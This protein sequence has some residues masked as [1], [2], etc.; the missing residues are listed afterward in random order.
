MT[1]PARPDGGGSRTASRL[2]Q[3]PPRRPGA[4]LAVR[5]VRA[6][7]VR[8]PQVPSAR[9]AARAARHR[10]RYGGEVAPGGASPGSPGADRAWASSA[11]AASVPA[12]IRYLAAGLVVGLVVAVLAAGGIVLSTLGQLGYTGTSTAVVQPG[13]SLWDL[14]SSTG[15]PDVAET[16]AV[17]VELNS[18]ETS[19]VRAGQR[20]VVP[21]P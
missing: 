16:V 14:A 4:P 3:A 7:A 21:V 5:T 15:A 18:L 10:L 11:P 19:S 6:P 17:I 8:P 12:A 13:Q 1:V 20:L 2:P 9:P